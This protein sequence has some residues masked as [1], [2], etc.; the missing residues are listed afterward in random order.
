[1]PSTVKVRWVEIDF[2]DFKNEL[3]KIIETWIENYKAFLKKNSSIKLQNI[4]TFMDRVDQGII[5]KP[6]DTTSE[7]DKKK[8]FSLLENIRD[9]DLLYPKIIELIPS[10]KGELEILKKHTKSENEDDPY[11]IEEKNVDSE[12]QRLIAQTEEVEKNVVELKKKVENANE[13]ISELIDK[14]KENFRTGKRNFEDEVE[15]FRKEFIENAPKELKDFSGEEI[16]NAYEIMDN[17]YDRTIKLDEQKKKNNDMEL[18]LKIPLSTNKQISDC[19]NDLKLY[20]SLLEY[21]A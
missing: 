16:K 4:K 3:T 19:L 14:E 15:A 5:N 8:F 7:E 20:K 12:E 1:M 17:Y 21:V 6:T 10:I 13:D 9:M 11:D 18:L 2:T